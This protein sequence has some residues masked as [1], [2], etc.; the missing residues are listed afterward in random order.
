MSCSLSRLQ[1]SRRKNSCCLLGW[2]YLHCSQQQLLCSHLPLQVQLSRDWC[3][4]RLWLG[5]QWG[6]Y[7][8]LSGPQGYRRKHCSCLRGLLGQHSCQ[9]LLSC[10]P[11]PLLKLQWP[12]LPLLSQ[13]WA[14]GK[15]PK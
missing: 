2:L 13:H 10:C 14:L 1:V 4:L 15:L 3:I 12:L 6:W 5:V 8:H 11:R 9:K 7:S